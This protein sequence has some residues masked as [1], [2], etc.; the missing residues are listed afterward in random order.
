MSEQITLA[1]IKR[2]IV[3]I[4]VEVELFGAAETFCNEYY[5]R[6]Q[7]LGNQLM[8]D[9]QCQTVEEAMSIPDE[10]VLSSAA[11]ELFEQLNKWLKEPGEF[12][13]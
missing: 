1:E 2:R 5:K 4:G 10:T 11:A 7:D 3:D 8:V 13:P 6:L 12:A 9:H